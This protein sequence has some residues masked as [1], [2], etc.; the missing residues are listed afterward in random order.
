[1]TART[2]T[3]AS[4][5]RHRRHRRPCASLQPGD[6]RRR[7][8][9]SPS[10]PAG[11]RCSALLAAQLGI[12]LRFGRRYCLPCVAYF[13][14][15]QP[16]FGE[17]EI[18]DS[19]PPKFANQVGLVVLTS[20]TVAHAVGLTVVGN[21]L[22]LIVAGLALLA[23]TTGFCVGCEMYRI[24]AQLRGIRRREIDRVELAELGEPQGTGGRG[25]LVV[26]FS[27]PTLHRMPDRPRRAGGGLR[28]AG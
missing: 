5:P 19:R 25:D 8:A 4:I 1:M 10:S 23:A 11:G 21:S 18:E 13:E 14:F 15:V 12:G 28:S 22:G 3:A 9:R 2:R 16:R 17:G 7:V 6:R 26:A 24:G 27:H 20:A